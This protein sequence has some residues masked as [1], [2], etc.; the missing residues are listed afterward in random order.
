MQLFI[1]LS[2]LAIYI[3]AAHR[4]KGNT[5][6]LLDGGKNSAATIEVRMVVPQKA[7]NL[8]ATWSIYTHNN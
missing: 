1:A 3:K 7:R 8:F 6:S 2:K 5:Y 4:G